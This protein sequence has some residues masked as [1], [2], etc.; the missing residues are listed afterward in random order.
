VRGHML[1]QLVA[2]RK[3]GGRAAPGDTKMLD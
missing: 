3:S 2:E 1:G